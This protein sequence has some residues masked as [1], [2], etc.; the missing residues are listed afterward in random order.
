MEEVLA[1]LWRDVLGVER[2]GIHTNFFSLGGHSLLATQLITRVRD[3]FQVELP[4][5]KF[6]ENPTIAGLAATVAEGQADKADEGEMAQLLVQLERLSDAE[7]EMLLAGHAPI[8]GQS[9]LPGNVGAGGEPG[10]A[11]LPASPDRPRYKANT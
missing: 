2:V 5:K 1:E 9:E 6:F 7:A 11:A 8:P 3:T 4:L 10:E